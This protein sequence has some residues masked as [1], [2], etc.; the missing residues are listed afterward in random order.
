MNKSSPPALVVIVTVLVAI[1]GVLYVEGS[2]GFIVN[3]YFWGGVGAFGGLGLGF[4]VEGPLILGLGLLDIL[5]GIKFYHA[6]RSSWALVMLSST[7]SVLVSFLQVGSKGVSFSLGSGLGIGIFPIILLLMIVYSYTQP[8]VGFYFQSRV[9]RRQLT[10]DLENQ[11]RRLDRE[12][13]AGK[14][15]R[16]EYTDQRATLRA[17]TGF[18]E[19]P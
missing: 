14:L 4:A 1:V 18:H 19:D 2:V 13:T 6:D 17:R 15:S 9:Q 5:A 7:L 8:S 11:M 16:D 10:L 12:Y 3:G